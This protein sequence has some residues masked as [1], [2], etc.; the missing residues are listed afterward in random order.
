[1]IKNTSSNTVKNIRPT[2]FFRASACK[3]LKNSEC[4]MYIPYS[5]TFRGNSVFQV[6]RKLLKNPECKK[7]IEYSENF[8]ATLFF[9][10]SASCSKIVNGEK[11]FNTV[12]IHLGAIRSIWASVVCNLD[13]SH[14]WLPPLLSAR[15][16]LTLFLRRRQW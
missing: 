3:L 13:Q 5:E 4:K 9:R 11:I 10:A 16:S 2:L 8:R 6:K 12:Y 7:Y 14:D 1:M 15:I